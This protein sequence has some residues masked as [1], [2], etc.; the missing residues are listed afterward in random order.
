MEWSA[1]SADMLGEIFVEQS[2]KCS[3]LF[4]AR[5]RVGPVV[6][7]PLCVC[8]TVFL[9]FNAYV[10]TAIPFCPSQGFA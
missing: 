7:S 10:H 3:L 5:A 4:V 6:P 8:T 1:S 2:V 9:P